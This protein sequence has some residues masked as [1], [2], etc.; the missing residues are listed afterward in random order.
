MFCLS[1]GLGAPVG[2]LLCGTSA[3]IEQ[4]RVA[5]KRL[6]GG[7]RQ[8]GV[9]AAAGLVALLG[10]GLAGWAVSRFVMDVPSYPETLI[11]SDILPNETTKLAHYLLPG[12]SHVEKRGSFTNTKGRVQKFM[13]A[14]QPPGEARAEW[15]FLHDLVYNVT[16]KLIPPGGIPIAV[17]VVVFNLIWLN[18]LMTHNKII[19][20]WLSLADVLRTEHF[21]KAMKCYEPPRQLVTSGPYLLPIHNTEP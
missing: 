5:R 10:G 17:G 20:T 2:S 15:D 19:S 11:V 9:L 13:Q 1:K 6:G 16:G 4:A 7:M 21:S 8:V 3:F 18:N 14:V 12:A